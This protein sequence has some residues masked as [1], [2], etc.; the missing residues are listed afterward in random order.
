MTR[1]F[2][3][4]ALLLAGFSGFYSCSGK[5]KQAPAIEISPDDNSIVPKIDIAGLK[6]EAAVLSAMQKVV[7]ARMADEKMKKD[8][9]D[10]N[11]N[12][13]ELVKLYT[14]VL[15]ASTEYSKTI[16]VPSRAV[17]FNNKINA[18]QEKLYA[19]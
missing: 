17:E 14:A 19:K 11:G 6:D 16:A 12:Y 4:A 9:P 3:L 8:N 1:K 5:N 15:G 7:D 18:I 2:L 10:Y 13:L